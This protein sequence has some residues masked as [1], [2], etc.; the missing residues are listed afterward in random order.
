MN[1]EAFAKYKAYLLAMMDLLDAKPLPEDQFISHVI[2]ASTKVFKGEEGMLFR[3]LTEME[4]TLVHL[5]LSLCQA[6]PKTLVQSLQ[7]IEQMKSGVADH[8]KWISLFRD[9]EPHKIF[10]NISTAICH[11][12]YLEALESGFIS[13]EFPYSVCY[14]ISDE[15]ICFTIY[16]REDL[17]VKPEVGT[18]LKNLNANY[19]SVGKD[20]DLAS[21]TPSSSDMKN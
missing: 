21:W 17:I 1:A 7:K 6:A 10:G 9:L 11:D 14:T 19:G 2:E 4:A 20:F 13:D 16:K 8:L 3:P 5:D 15:Q 18:H 12:V